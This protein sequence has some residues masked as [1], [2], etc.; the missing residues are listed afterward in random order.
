MHN[1]HRYFFHTYKLIH[2]KM[3]VTYLQ[4]HM[5]IYLCFVLQNLFFSLSDSRLFLLWQRSR[6]REG[7]LKKV[8]GKAKDEEILTGICYSHRHHAASE[9]EGALLV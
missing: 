2:T 3:Y 4:C 7:R 8:S 9:R 6:G 1:S 5:V